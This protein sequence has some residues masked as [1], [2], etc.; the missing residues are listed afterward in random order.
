[1]TERN[2]PGTV[3]TM[4]LQCLS[5]GSC[6]SLGELDA[7]LDAGYQQIANA[8]YAFIR[9]GFLERIEHGCYQLTP[10]GLEGAK[11][12][13]VA[14]TRPYRPYRQN[15]RKR[16]K[17]SMRQRAWNA[18]RISGS[19]TIGDIV[20][21]CAK[22][23]LWPEKNLHRYFRALKAAGYLAELPRR[24]RGFKRYRLL[25]DTG[26]NAPAELQAQKAVLDYNLSEK[27]EVVPCAR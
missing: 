12:G 22:D 13:F 18:M 5:D 26:P 7:C 10:E 9:R 20:I 23:E 25:K 2:E 16:L 4:L 11:S 1:M 27:G 8:A 15:L 3:P 6:R 24:V 21:A 19:F 14:N 17:D